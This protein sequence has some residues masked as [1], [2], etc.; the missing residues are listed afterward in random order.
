[1]ATVPLYR[2]LSLPAPKE[3]KNN[4]KTLNFQEMKVF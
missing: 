2:D 3:S 4:K 1:M